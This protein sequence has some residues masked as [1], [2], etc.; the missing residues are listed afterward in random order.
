MSASQRLVGAG[1]ALLGAGPASRAVR[2][3]G[4]ERVGIGGA[5]DAAFGAGGAGERL[6]D[7]DELASLATVEFAPPEELT[8]PQGGVVLREAVRQEHKVAWLIDEAIDGSIELVDQGPGKVS[9]RRGKGLG[10]PEAAPVLDQMFDGR[11][12]LDLGT[13]DK[14]F[15]AGWSIVGQPAAALGR[16][17][18][19]LG[20]EG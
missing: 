3:R 2:R 9:L 7:A 13:Y 19:P 20:P 1:A 14:P 15:A 8:P 12:Q 4:R 5:A 11:Q 10:D 16:H 6:V 17:E 18:R